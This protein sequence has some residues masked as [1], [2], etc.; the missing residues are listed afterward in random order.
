MTK[1]F[2]T[3]NGVW[4]RPMRD[5]LEVLV[6]RFGAWYVVIDQPKGDVLSQIVYPPGIEKAP[7]DHEKAPDL[8]A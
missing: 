6:E 1:P 4:L 7:L 3:I 5:R 2:V 8:E